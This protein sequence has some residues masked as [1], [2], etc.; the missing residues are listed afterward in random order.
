MTRKRLRGPGTFVAKV[1]TPRCGNRVNA[2]A[3]QA[4]KANGTALAADTNALAA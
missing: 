4:V 2:R 1:T 3:A